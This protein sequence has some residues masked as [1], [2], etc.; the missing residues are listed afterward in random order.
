MPAG[1][2]VV[3]PGKQTLLTGIVASSAPSPCLNRMRNTT[4]VFSVKCDAGAHGSQ[5]S[6][7]L[8]EEHLN[9]VKANSVGRRCTIGFRTH[10]RF[11][12]MDTVASAVASGN[13][14][15]VI[16]LRARLL[17]TPK[18]WRDKTARQACD[19]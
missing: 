3:L 14:R 1:V 4:S 2:R 19:E 6:S 18:L 17:P 10:C 13:Q 8:S 12:L 7:F 9:F 15:R 16:R 5:R 11:N